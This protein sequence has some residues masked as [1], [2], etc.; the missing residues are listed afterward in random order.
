MRM[1]QILRSIYIEKQILDIAENVRWI[2]ISPYKILMVCWLAYSMQTECISIDIDKEVIRYDGIASILRSLRNVEDIVYCLTDYAKSNVSNIPDDVVKHVERQ[3]EQLLTQTFPLLTHIGYTDVLYDDVSAIV[4]SG[5]CSQGYT[6]CMCLEE[7][8]RRTEQFTALDVHYRTLNN[9]S[10]MH[11][12]GVVTK[13]TPHKLRKQLTEFFEQKNTEQNQLPNELAIQCHDVMAKRENLYA[14]DEMCSDWYAP[15][16]LYAE[17]VQRGLAL[18]QL[19]QIP[20]CD[21]TAYRTG[22]TRD[23]LYTVGYAEKQYNIK[24]LRVDQTGYLY[25]NERIVNYMIDYSTLLHINSDAVWQAVTGYTQES[26]YKAYKEHY[27]PINM[28]QEQIEMQQFI[29]ILQEKHIPRWGILLDFTQLTALPELCE[30]SID[31]PDVAQRFYLELSAN[32]WQSSVA[33]FHKLTPKRLYIYGQQVQKT[34]NA[35]ALR[36]TIFMSNTLRKCIQLPYDR[37]LTERPYKLC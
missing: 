18:K 30:L 9:V 14:Q 26:S 3:S 22:L 7:L 6:L 24:S 15:Y 11:A 23:L 29:Q 19:C 2:V 25:I 37:L 4:T 21:I 13:R 10:A 28:Q 1:E 32:T 27:Q 16:I 31:N 33:A 34:L 12:L 17:H 20:V 5:V 8:S 36:A 35:G